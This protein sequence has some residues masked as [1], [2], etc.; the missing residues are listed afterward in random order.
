MQIPQVNDATVLLQNLL[1]SYNLSRFISK[2]SSLKPPQPA[3]GDR[4]KPRRLTL[5][6]CQANIKQL[7]CLLPTHQSLTS[8]HISHSPPKAASFW[9]GS[10]QPFLLLVLCVLCQVQ[11]RVKPLLSVLLL[12]PLLQKSAGSL[13]N[14]KDYLALVQLS[15]FPQKVSWRSPTYLH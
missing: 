8:Q 14:G 9:S 2:F 15:C 7:Q 1:Y 4:Y 5:H 13:P 10:L 11:E 12:A 3:V 6:K